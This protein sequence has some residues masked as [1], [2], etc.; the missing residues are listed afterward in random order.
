LNPQKKKK[1]RAKME[2]KNWV[3]L[4]TTGIPNLVDNKKDEKKKK[5]KKTIVWIKLKR[6][7]PQGEIGFF[8]GG[9]PKGGTGEK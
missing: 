2:R 8:L 4:K 3:V 9:N 6:G 5:K 1:K 7:N